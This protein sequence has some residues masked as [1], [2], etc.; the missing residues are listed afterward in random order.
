MEM[1]MQRL[2]TYKSPGTDK[3]PGEITKTAGWTIR[4]E[5]HKIFCSIWNKDEFSD[6]R[7]VSIIVRYL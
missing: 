1:A 2:N 6:E 7:E 3:I 4:F 5:I